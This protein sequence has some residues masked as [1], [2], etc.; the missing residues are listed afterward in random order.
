MGEVPLY[1]STSTLAK[2]GSKTSA[3]ERVLVLL[4]KDTS[5][6]RKRFLLGPYCKPM[7]RALR[8]S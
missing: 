4:Y 8:W 7:P 1:N 6:I 2:L 3:T 5:L